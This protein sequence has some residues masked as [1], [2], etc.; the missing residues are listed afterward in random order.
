MKSAAPQNH[1]RYSNSASFRI[2][3]EEGMGAE[4]NV[5][6][7]LLIPGYVISHSFFGIWG[8]G[9]AHGAQY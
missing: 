3:T 6:R 9:G 4:G 7:K 8:R 1:V 2:L 5:H